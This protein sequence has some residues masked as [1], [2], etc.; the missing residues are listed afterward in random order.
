MSRANICRVKQTARSSIV[1]KTPVT[2]PVKVNEQST[3]GIVGGKVEV[4]RCE[5]VEVDGF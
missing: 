4:V 1:E 5:I 2:S 3:D